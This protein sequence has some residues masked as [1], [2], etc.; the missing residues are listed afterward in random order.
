[1]LLRSPQWPL[2]LLVL[3]L[4]ACACGNDSGVDAAASD[5]GLDAGYDAGVDAGFD[6]GTDAGRDAGTAGWVR[7][8]GFPEGCA[9]ERAENPG[10]LYQP[11]WEPCAE[12]P[13]GCLR[14]VPSNYI[15]T[16]VGWHDGEHGYAYMIGVGTLIVDLDRGAIAAW[17]PPALATRDGVCDIREVGIGDGYGAAYM[18]FRHETS[19]EQNFDRIYHAPLAEIGAVETPFADVTPGFTATS[20]Q[21][22]GVS[23]SIVAAEMQPAGATVIFG[24]GRWSAL[25]GDPVVGTSQ[26]LTVAGDFAFWEDWGST[27]RIAYGSLD[28]PAMFLRDPAPGRI[29]ALHGDGADLAWVEINDD[30]PTLDLYTAPVV[31]DA[32]ELAARLVGSIEGIQFTGMGGGWFVRVIADPEQLVLTELASGR[33]KTWLAAEGELITG[34]PPTYVS[35]T[36][37]LIRARTSDATNYWLRLD[38]RSIPWDDER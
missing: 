31:F 15:R 3:A 12:Q 34:Y 13:V 7:M 19:A 21:R 2:L 8:P 29:R 25:S 30:P 14:E 16:T 1:M 18:F 24:E 5:A 11:E 33:T 22:L 32:S 26:R 20:P 38:P 27:I 17:R 9:I 10:V 35:A 36:E 6:A 23:R 28:Q 4:S 37:I